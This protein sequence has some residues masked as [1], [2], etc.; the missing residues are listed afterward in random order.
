MG[1]VEQITVYNT[2]DG[3]AFKTMEDAK[4]HDRYLS[5]SKCYDSPL[6]APAGDERI[7]WKRVYNWMYENR[8]WIENLIHV[9]NDRE[10]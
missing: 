8:E 4:H 1:K 6:R 9:W 3:T 5:F 10:E 2:E 7:P